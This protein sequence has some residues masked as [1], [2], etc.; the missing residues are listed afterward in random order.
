MPS[1]VPDSW[2]V[3]V[4][5]MGMASAPLGAQSLGKELTTTT[6]SEMN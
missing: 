4:K 2:E 5:K 3:M 6:D 1:T